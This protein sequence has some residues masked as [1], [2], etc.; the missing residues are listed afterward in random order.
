[1]FFAKV[2]L[3]IVIVAARPVHG[4]VCHLLPSGARVFWASGG[5]VTGDVLAASAGVHEENVGGWST[6]VLNAP[7]PPRGVVVPVVHL[8]QSDPF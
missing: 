3:A 1:L 7:G 5:S 6:V 8:V 2:Y 4:G